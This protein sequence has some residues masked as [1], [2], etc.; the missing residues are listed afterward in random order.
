M[1]LHVSYIEQ[2]V[3][4]KTLWKLTA[5]DKESYSGYSAQIKTWNKTKTWICQFFLKKR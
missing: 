2:M 5:S 4:N 3:P 1:V